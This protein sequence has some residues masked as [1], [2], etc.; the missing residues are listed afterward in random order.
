VGEAKTEVR[1]G[2]G[3][4][5]RLARRLLDPGAA[6]VDAAIRGALEELGRE[7]GAERVHAFVLSD[8]G[9][10]VAEAWEW[11]RDGLPPRDFQA[12][13]GV[14]VESFRWSMARWLRGETVV[15]EDSEA[16]PEEAA[17]ERQASAELGIR[18]Y[19]Q[20]PLFSGGRLR[21][22]L[23]S[24]AVEPGH[25]WSDADTA[26]M[27]R[28][29]EVLIG[30]IERRRR[31]ENAFREE[32]LGLRLASLGTLGA[33]LAHEVTGPLSYV[34][35]NLDL[36]HRLVGEA[37]LHVPD[38]LA[39]EL[40]DVLADCRE[41][42]ER[43]RGVVGDLRTFT[44]RD[45]TAPGPIDLA[46]V[47]D[48]ALRMAQNEIRHR[49]RL[50]RRTEGAPWV[51]GTG[52]LL[53]QVFL[54]LLLD[55]ARALPAGRADEHLI[56]VVVRRLGDGRVAVE[57]SDTGRGLPP[58]VLPRIFDPFFSARGP[59][60][61]RGVGLALC[62][63][64]VTSF[65]GE[66]AAESALGG[67][68][69]FKVVLREAEPQEEGLE[70][71]AS[72]PAARTARAPRAVPRLLVIDDDRVFLKWC[73]RALRDYD[74][75]VAASG[76]EGLAALAADPDR[77]LVLVDVM[78]PELTGED[79]FDAVRH[80]HPALAERIVF[81]TGGTF[82]EPLQAFLRRVPNRRV[83]KPFEAAVVQELLD[84]L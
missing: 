55:A 83:H 34:L 44:R 73:A 45:D 7:L 57:V 27:A 68:T 33:G 71:G 42:A 4:V 38:A 11:V 18:A 9:R 40:A 6:G 14:V 30:A 60:G 76:R 79:V 19:V 31:D 51:V 59:A 16:L 35:G 69:T 43:I 72:S 80:L 50:F 12:F 41:G 66:I 63:H 5:S 24:D 84:E 15:V 77:D 56:G 25:A 65:G 1:A 48:F 37:R 26:L 3:V 54:T 62:H 78:M 47:L 29:G 70:D 81:I 32:E 61:G 75:E 2:E 23:G 52:S 21:G 36:L 58:E 46:E 28:A 20:V 10:A 64:I 53:G 22:W 74:I 8:D 82:A 17:A 39:T 49:A 67:G 13:R